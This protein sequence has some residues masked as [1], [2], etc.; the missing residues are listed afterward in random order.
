MR[1]SGDNMGED[2]SAMV[3]RD[4]HRK[5]FLHGSVR[6]AIA[7]QR[8]QRSGRNLVVPMD[9]NRI[10]FLDLNATATNHHP[11]QQSG[12][13]LIASKNRTPMSLPDLNVTVVGHLKWVTVAVASVTKPRPKGARRQSHATN[14][15]PSPT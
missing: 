1:T 11:L 3:G 2:G 13:N 8:L 4:P 15:A 10:S 6:T 12:L 9:R 14:R 5:R 7:R